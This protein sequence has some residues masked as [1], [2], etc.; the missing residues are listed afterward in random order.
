MDRL[1]LV[2]LLG[3]LLGGCADVLL[4]PGP[5]AEAEGLVLSLE[6]SPLEISPGDTVRIVARLTNTNRRTVTLGFGSACQIM[7]YVE[8]A[9]GEVVMPQGGGWICA[10]VIT[11]LRLEPGQTAQRE[12]TWT[13]QTTRYEPPMWQPIQEPLPAGQYQIRVAM[14]QTELNG[15]LLS[16]RTPSIPLTLR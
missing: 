8:N 12:F 4:N 5:S 2:A 16:L 7:P 6:A 13:G 11:S 10:A 1:L 15:R 9:A 14:E 3:L